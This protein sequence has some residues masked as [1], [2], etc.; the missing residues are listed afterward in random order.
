MPW[1]LTLVAVLMALP[2]GFVHGRGVPAPERAQVAPDVLSAPLAPRDAVGADEAARPGA[3]GTVAAP[4]PCEVR[5]RD[6]DWHD[7][8][9]N[10]DVPARLY[11]PAGRCDEAAVPLVVFSHGLGGSREGYSYLGRYWAAHGYASLHVQHVGSDRKLWRGSPFA[12]ADRL[13]AATTA[14]EARA[15]G[16]DVT[17][18]LDQVFADAPLAAR[19]DAGRIVAAGHSYGANPTLLV[20]GAR[21]A[22]SGTLADPRIKGGIVLSAPAFAGGLDPRN[23][24]ASVQVPTLHVTTTEDDIQLPGYASGAADRIALYQ[25]VGGPRVLAVFNHG[26]HSIFTDRTSPGGS[27][28]NGEVKLATQQLT[29]AWL[30]WLFD[31]D[32]APVQA[33]QQQ[34]R[35]LTAQFEVKGEPTALRMRAYVAAHVAGS[36]LPDWPEPAARCGAPA[37]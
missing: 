17:F 26:P 35:P 34:Y 30:Q 1:V 11:L 23:V 4:G 3:A 36:A 12:M 20:S 24:L 28:L 32:C 8:A 5:T 27:T 15:R 19:V 25:A 33:W 14:D 22:R 29:V 31:G 18:A 37:A 13:R 2:F 21:A 16:E 7:T 9:R 10:R 6:L